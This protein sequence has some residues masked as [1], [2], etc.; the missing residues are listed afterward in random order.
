MQ[1]IARFGSQRE[2]DGVAKFLDNQR[3]V[4]TQ[5]F[6]NGAI[7]ETYLGDVAMAPIAKLHKRTLRD[8]GFDAQEHVKV[9]FRPEDLAFPADDPSQRQAVRQQI[10]K[11]LQAQSQ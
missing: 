2:S 11:L 5:G 8:V 7:A 3:V 1:V 9:A 6:A 4:E 10:D